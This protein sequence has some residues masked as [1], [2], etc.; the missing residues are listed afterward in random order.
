MTLPIALQRG[1]EEC[2]HYNANREY[3][4]DYPHGGVQCFPDCPKRELWDW[5]E[6]SECPD[7]KW[8]PD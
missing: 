6:D 8:R 1:C 5:G 7:F 3:V 4:G 2:A